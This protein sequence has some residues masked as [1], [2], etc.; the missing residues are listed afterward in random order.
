MPAVPVRSA[1]MHCRQRRLW[2]GWRSDRRDGLKCYERPA[3]AA[4]AAFDRLRDGGVI[5]DNS[6]GIVFTNGI[7]GE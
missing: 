6:F 2:C 3:A 4:A 7:A 1:Y 5:A